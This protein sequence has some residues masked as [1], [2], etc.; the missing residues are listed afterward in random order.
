[1][2]NLIIANLKMNLETIAQR[3]AY[4]S[5]T[6][7]IFQELLKRNEN[8]IVFCPP[9]AHLDHFAHTIGKLPV[10]LGAQDCF[11]ELYGSYTGF[12]SPKMITSL[13]AKYVILGH[14]E[15]REFA[16]ENDE[17]VFKK[18]VASLRVNLVPVVCVGYTKNDEDEME[19]IRQQINSLAESLSVEDFQKIVFAYEPVWAI[20]SGKTPS[21]EEIHTVVLFIK[22]VIAKNFGRELANQ[23]RIIYGGSVTPENV[24]EIC[25]KAFVN[26]VLVGGASLSPQKFGNLVQM[27]S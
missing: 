12:N 20:G 11:W 13:G 5:Q 18:V 2:K 17:M 7:E 10:E 16:E 1:M 6:F 24:R 9:I 25:E 4:C 23:I 14:S 3:D 26:G 19:N 15:R 22:T 21:I 27:L 8:Q